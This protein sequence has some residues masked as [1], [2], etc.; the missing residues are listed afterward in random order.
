MEVSET[1]VLQ[2]AYQA[3][4]LAQNDS[5]VRFRC[6]ISVPA[7]SSTSIFDSS[8]ISELYFRHSDRR[9]TVRLLR[10]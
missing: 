1:S 2:S 7:L 8:A 6:C 3:D 10:Q 5:M 4:H 9:S